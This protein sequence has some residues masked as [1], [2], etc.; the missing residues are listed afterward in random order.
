[1]AGQNVRFADSVIREEAVGCLG[2]R[3]ILAD[4]RNALSNGASNLREQLAESVAEPR[5]PKLASRRSWRLLRMRVAKRALWAIC[6]NKPWRTRRRFWRCSVGY[7]L[8]RSRPASMTGALRFTSTNSALMA[9]WPR[10]PAIRRT[11]NR[12]PTRRLRRISVSRLCALHRSPRRK[13]QSFIWNWLAA[14]TVPSKRQTLPRI[15]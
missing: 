11:G 4:E 9:I 14:R 12:D 1:M 5:V 7:C 2:I 3:P 15:E 8:T 13:L 6:S 10:S